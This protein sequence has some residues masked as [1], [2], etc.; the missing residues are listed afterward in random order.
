MGPGRVAVRAH[1]SRA[2]DREVRGRA[3]V[4]SDG[5]LRPRNPGLRGLC[6]GAGSDPEPFLDEVNAFV[7]RARSSS[8]NHGA[9][10]T[11]LIRIACSRSMKRHPSERRFAMSTRVLATHSSR[12]HERPSAIGL[13]SFVS[14]CSPEPRSGHDAAGALPRLGSLGIVASDPSA[15]LANRWMLPSGP[16]SRSSRPCRSG[17][18]FTSAPGSTPWRL[19]S[20]PGWTQVSPGST[21]D[22]MPWSRGLM[23]WQLDSTLTWSNT[24]ARAIAL[25]FKE[26]SCD[27]TA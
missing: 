26:S 24:R 5:S 19:D 1:A 23:R 3:R 22:S 15:T 20:T 25:D 12:F 14:S 10:S 8:S 27:V 18:L 6:H 7:T 13:P 11:P 9:T 17:R 4:R 16:P 2:I 21:R